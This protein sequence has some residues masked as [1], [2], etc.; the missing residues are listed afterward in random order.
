MLDLNVVFFVWNVFNFFLTSLSF[1][2]QYVYLFERLYICDWCT[3]SKQFS[4]WRWKVSVWEIN[5]CDSR[6]YVTFLGITD[7]RCGFRS[8]AKICGEGKKTTFDISQISIMAW[9]MF[10]YVWLRFKRYKYLRYECCLIDKYFQYL[11]TKE[12][13][14]RYWSG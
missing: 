1:W 2:L 10:I 7:F 8:V 4:F 13:S 3:F 6:L 5:K 12:R 11:Q 9:I 14:Q